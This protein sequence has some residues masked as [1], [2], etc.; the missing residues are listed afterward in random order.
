MRYYVTE[1]GGR[2]PPCIEVGG[3]TPPCI[4][5]E[6]RTPP[7]IGI[8]RLYI[9]TLVFDVAFSAT[10]IGFHWYKNLLFF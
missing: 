6:R 5:V 1:V 4:E 7:C 10:I 2:T 8:V 9:Y 3:R